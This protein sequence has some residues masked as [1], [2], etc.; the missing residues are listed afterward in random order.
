[1]VLRC[2]VLARFD[3]LKCHVA[4][5]SCCDPP[6]PAR[7]SMLQGDVHRVVLACAQCM[8]LL[9]TGLLRRRC[10][11]VWYCSPRPPAAMLSNFGVSH[12][13]LAANPVSEC[14][15]LPGLFA[16]CCLDV[17]PVPGSRASL[18]RRRVL[19]FVLGGL[20]WLFASATLVRR[21]SD[22]R[23]LFCFPANVRNA[24]LIAAKCPGLWLRSCAAV[25]GR[26]PYPLPASS[27]FMGRRF[28][29]FFQF[30]MVFIGNP[31]S[32]TNRGGGVR[33]IL[34]SKPSW[35]RL[36]HTCNPT[37]TRGR[38]W[39]QIVVVRGMVRMVVGVVWR[40]WYGW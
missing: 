12:G 4:E 1:M 26:S 28:L 29:R 19:P 39:W 32:G 35:L 24:V 15:F 10:A 8:G 16:E 17:C 14:Q 34:R 18:L 7:S 27:P 33:I 20:C 31:R 30:V 6:R 40:W 13:W 11:A 3:V 2:V 36:R 25:C 21:G 37:T 23:S 5:N 22:V 38:R 9:R